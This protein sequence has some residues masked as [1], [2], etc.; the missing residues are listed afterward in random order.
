MQP[1]TFRISKIA[2]LFV[3]LITLVSC[4]EVFEQDLSD[5]SISIIL[6]QNNTVTP[7][8]NVHFKWKE[9]QDAT[10]YTLEVVS[11][12]FS[13]IY[14]FDVDS[15]FSANEIFLNLVPGNYQWRV[16]ANNNASKTDFSLPYNLKIDTSSNLT[17]QVVIL[18]SPANNTVSNSIS[19]VFSWN[20]MSVAD[21]YDFVLKE[22]SNFN[23]GTVVSSNYNTTSTSFTVNNLQEKEYVWGVRAKNNI[24]SLTNYTTRAF[25]VDTT[26]PL[27]PSLALPAN[28]SLVADTTSIQFTWLNPTDI[29]GAYKSTVTSVIE[30]A[31]DSLFTLPLHH[32]INSNSTSTTYTFN[33]VGVYYWRMY[34]KD[35]ANN[36][37]YYNSTVRKITTF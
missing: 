5:Q 19:S 15:T 23:T 29:G 25:Y 33:S 31:T 11:P 20:A 22:G 18:N 27:A 13:N 17:G 14:Y 36:E 12:S 2:S 26:H 30:I 10:S 32:T 8:R 6:P 9:L 4:K 37:S 35:A 1:S 34:T 16:R 3:L 21:D 28:N 7:I 24:P